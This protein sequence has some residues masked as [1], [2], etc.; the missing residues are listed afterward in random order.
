LWGRPQYTSVIV[1]LGIP[2]RARGGFPLNTRIAST[3]TLSVVLLAVSGGQALAA[4]GST[5]LKPGSKDSK[6]V[7][8]LQADLRS[9]GFKVKVDGNFGA[10]TKTA[11]EAFQRRH[12]LT[13]DGV[14]GQ[15]TFE[16]LSKA[17]AGNATRTASYHVTSSFGAYVLRAGSRRHAQVRILQEDLRSLGYGVA[18]DGVF[19]ASTKIA[20]EAFQRAH[21]LLADGVV[22]KATFAALKG[23]ET[24]RGGIM[25]SLITYVVEPKDTLASIAAEFGTTVAAL[26]AANHLSQSSISVG[27]TLLVPSNPTSDLGETIAQDSLKFLGVPYVY[28]GSSP[29][30]FDCS[31]LVQYVAGLVGISLPRTVSDQYASG[32]PVSRPDLQP[33]DLVF[34]D[35][36]GHVDHVGIY[37]GDGEFVQAP[38]SG[39]SVDIQSLSMSY[40]AD[41]YVGARSI[42]GG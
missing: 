2:G 15:K 22:G 1:P 11:V 37:I 30:G 19:G 6:S 27:E 41:R 39:Q 25:R 35:V 8:I 42:T 31:G 7:R 12:G 36:Y 16:A 29:S 24:S 21:H 26:E 9:L 14:V 5:V 13:A 34:F 18:V 33:G 17:L 4:F 32:S 20:V 23:A 28:G 38:A 3:C 10:S 40:W